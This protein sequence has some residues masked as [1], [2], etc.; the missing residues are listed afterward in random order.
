[1][2][3]IQ[4]AIN[5]L[6]L[7]GIAHILTF[8]N[9]A[10]SFNPFISG[11]MQGVER[12]VDYFKA[13]L[14]LPDFVIGALL[15]ALL[16]TISTVLPYRMGLPARFTLIPGNLFILNAPAAKGIAGYWWVNAL[17]TLLF[18]LHVWSVFFIIRLITP[19]ER[20]SRAFDA[21]TFY[22]TPISRLP[23]PAQGILLVL[24]SLLIAAVSILTLQSDPAVAEALDGKSLTAL[25]T[26]DGLAIRLLRFV[27]LAILIFCDSLRII[28]YALL[29]F[30]IGNLICAL[31]QWRNGVLLCLE[32]VN[33][34]MGR[35]ARNGAIGGGFDFT[36]LIYM[37]AVNMLH[38]VITQVLVSMILSINFT[39]HLPI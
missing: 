18:F 25:F 20:T 17:K 37:I 7:L 19:R 22:A 30:L 1:M 23:L 9:R 12:I 16:F 39:P 3:N 8:R 6:I 15:I 38:V 28:N 4:T 26:D 27:W 10:F 29:V 34:L 32:G 2:E 31:F 13:A 24:L 33:M 14:R 11:P 21:Y 35:F 36:P 5:F